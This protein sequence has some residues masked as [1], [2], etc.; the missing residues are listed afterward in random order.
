MYT[1][2]AVLKYGNKINGFLIADAGNVGSI[3]RLIDLDDM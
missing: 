2:K 1:V 3:V